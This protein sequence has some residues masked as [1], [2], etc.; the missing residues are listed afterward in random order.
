MFLFL[1]FRGG[2][3][4]VDRVLRV[5]FCAAARNDGSKFFFRVGWQ[6][7]AFR[8]LTSRIRLTNVF[9]VDGDDF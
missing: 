8:G 7:P 4:V 3:L 1:A 2:C 9:R 5:S 6:L